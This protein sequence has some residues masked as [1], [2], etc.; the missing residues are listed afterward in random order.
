MREIPEDFKNE[1][2]QFS[3]ATAVFF[4][5][6]MTPDQKVEHLIECAE[7][8]PSEEHRKEAEHYLDI[9]CRACGDPECLGDYTHFE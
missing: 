2:G 3:Y 9:L 7:S 8:L 6:D 4:A 5:D 1:N